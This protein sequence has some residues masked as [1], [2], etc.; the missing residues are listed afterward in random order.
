MLQNILLRKKKCKEYVAQ[1]LEIPPHDLHFISQWDYHLDTFIQSGPRG[2]L[3]VPDL[4]YSKEIVSHLELYWSQ[5]GLTAHDG[6]VLQRYVSQAKLLEKELGPL[7]QKV[8]NELQEA[9]FFVIPSP[10]CYYDVHMHENNYTRHVRFLNAVTGW[11]NGH[12]YYITLGAKV[13][14]SLGSIFMKIQEEF[15]KQ[16]EPNIKVYFV[17][18]DPQQKGDFEQAMALLNQVKNVSEKTKWR[19]GP[20]AGVHCLTFEM[21]TEDH[22]I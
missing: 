7:L 8:K 5:Y 9:D 10:A 3:F 15:L 6:L 1:I 18:E 14:P 11:G 13:G 12:Y 22:A 20:N 17:G 19:Q 4:G 2:S 16:Y 21:E